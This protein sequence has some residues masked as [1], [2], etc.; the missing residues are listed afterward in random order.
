[1][2]LKDTLSWTKSPLIINAPMGGIATAD[3][4]IAVTKAGGLGQIGGVPDYGDLSKQLSQAESALGRTSNGLLPIGVGILSFLMSQEDT[5]PI[6][7]RY[8]PAVVWIFASH[9]LSDYSAWAKS[10]RERLPSSQLWIQIGSVGGAVRVA[11]DA[12]PDVLCLQGID[13]GGHG[14]EKG[15]GIISLR[16]ADGRAVAAALVL[17]AEGVVMGTRF[18]SAPETRV[19]PQYREAIIHA[20]DGGQSTVRD[21][22]FDELRGPNQWPGDYDGRS[23][24]TASY[25]DKAEGVHIDEIRQ[26]HADAALGESA[27]Y[28]A[29]G[30]SGRAA[31]W[32]GTGV[33]L[34]TKAQRAAEVV[35]EVRQQAAASLEAVRS[36]FQD[37]AN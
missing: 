17:G 8:R 1:M 37:T 14:F 30:T 33:G 22:V 20:K 19:H 34:V 28:A 4:A 5:M 36:R 9:N 3:L 25:R 12:K 26:R 31:T 29:D 16:I 7:E 24:R 32:A 6:L 27:G 11:K 18:L 35:E 23:I 2:E 15:A 13:A 10:I 21:K